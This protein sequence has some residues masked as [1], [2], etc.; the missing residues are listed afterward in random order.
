MMMIFGTAQSYAKTNFMKQKWNLK[1]QGIEYDEKNQW[2][3]SLM[4]QASDEMKSKQ[5]SAIS[6]KMKSGQKLTGSD[7]EYLKAHAPQLYTEYIKIV[8]EREQYKEELKKCKTKDEVN[9]LNTMKVQEFMSQIHS[10]EGSGMS[11][12]AKQAAMDRIQMHM[13]NIQNEHQAFVQSTR[14]ASLKWQKEIDREEAEKEAKIQEIQEEKAAQ[15]A[16]EKEDDTPK[17]EDEH[18]DNEF[19]ENQI[20]QE[21]KAETPKPSPD[22]SVILEAFRQQA[23]VIAKSQ[24]AVAATSLNETKGQAVRQRPDEASYQQKRRKFSARA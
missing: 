3:A 22:T 6:Y 13:A 1:K 5:I 4:Q 7:L 19:D 15:K 11:A 23:E 9:N 16:E 24:E 18:F 21:V 2:K 12:G 10:V 8:A 17:V 20:E 14:Y